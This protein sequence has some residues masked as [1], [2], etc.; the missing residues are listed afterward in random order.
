MIWVECS[1]AAYESREKSKRMQL[2]CLLIF[3]LFKQFI[4]NLQAVLLVW[5]RTHYMI[6]SC[7]CR[8]H[9]GIRHSI[10][11]YSLGSFIRAIQKW[12]H[13]KNLTSYR[14]IRSGNN[15]KRIWHSVLAVRCNNVQCTIIIRNGVNA[16]R[17]HICCE[18]LWW[19]VSGG[20][21]IHI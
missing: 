13:S 15:N 14:S 18:R 12:H 19:F 2:N 11:S 20:F 1:V 8:D 7:S 3:V 17:I 10:L 16:M 4:Y 6:D 21:L 5:L 9:Y